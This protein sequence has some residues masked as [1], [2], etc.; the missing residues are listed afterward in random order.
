MKRY[1]DAIIVGGGL[2]GGL[3]AYRMKQRTPAMEILVLERG[4]RFGGNHLWSFHET[5]LTVEQLEWIQPFVVR[6]WPAYDVIFPRYRRT[7]HSGYASITSDRF[8]ERV[9]E[10]VRLLDGLGREPAELSADFV[11]LDNGLRIHGGFVIDARGWPEPSPIPAAYQKFVGLQL[12]LHG[13]HGLIHPVLMD[14]REPQVDG[15]RFFYLL[16]MDE[17]SLLIEDTR[18]SDGSDLDVDA[19]RRDIMDYAKKNGW[20]VDAIEREERGVLAIPL[21]GA[22]PAG[23]PGLVRAGGRAGLFHATTGYSLPDA[24]R[25]ADAL[26]RRDPHETSGLLAWSEERAR[27]HWERNGFYRFLNRL[28]FRAARPPERY[29]IMEMFYQ[30]TPELIARFYAGRTTWGDRLRLLSGAPPVPIGRAIRC[31]LESR[32]AA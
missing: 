15:Y 17:S 13:P 1:Y 22:L 26:A 7:V 8:H 2:A 25:F 27:L 14:V 28:F 6:R 10:R 20:R 16:P 23:E 30:R 4:E 31:I 3:A 19:V 11:V 29:R 5:D 18:Y 24:I 9:A 32:R 12:R 21:E